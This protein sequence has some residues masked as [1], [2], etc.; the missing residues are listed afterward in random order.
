MQNAS[1]REAPTSFCPQLLHSTFF[2]QKMEPAERLALPW[3][4]C[5]AVYKTAAV[6]TEPRRQNGG[7]PRC[8]PVLCGLR[9]RCIAAM[10]A[11]RTRREGGVEP[12]RQG[13]CS[14]GRH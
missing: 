5:P 14:P 2:L 4:E 13:L 11:T 8:C 9:D 6:A 7:S 1:T 10:L 3:G 12:P